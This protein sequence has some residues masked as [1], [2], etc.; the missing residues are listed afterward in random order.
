[1]PYNPSSFV[2]VLVYRALRLSSEIGSGVV[3]GKA[4]SG[5]DTALRFTV[6]LQYLVARV[7]GCAWLCYGSGKESSADMQME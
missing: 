6:L 2:Y 7:G 5:C 4:G 1:V 3:Y